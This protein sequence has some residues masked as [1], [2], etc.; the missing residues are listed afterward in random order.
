[1]FFLVQRAWILCCL[2]GWFTFGGGFFEDESIGFANTRGKVG[3]RDK[4]KVTRS[5]IISV[6]GIAGIK[7]AKCLAQ[8][9][10]GKKTNSS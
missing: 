1:M 7:R 10:G 8:A 5:G 9:S 4:R 3:G 6:C 2:K